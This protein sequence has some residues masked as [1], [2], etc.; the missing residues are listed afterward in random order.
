MFI[1]EFTDYSTLEILQ[2]LAWINPEA[3]QPVVIFYK[4]GVTW[5]A[6]RT[7]SASVSRVSSARSSP[8]SSWTWV[9]QGWIFYH[10]RFGKLHLWELLQAGLHL[11]KLSRGLVVAQVPQAVQLHH[12]L[13]ELAGEGLVLGVDVGGGGEVGE[14]GV[15]A[16]RD[17]QQ[18]C[19]LL[20]QSSL[21]RLGGF[22]DWSL[23]A[24]GG[25]FKLRDASVHRL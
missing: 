21:L 13:L 14:E 4:E 9:Q 5:R 17:R 24:N 7:S 16:Q 20:F 18:H 25:E 12:L 15:H 1:V 6:A 11:G 23:W 8:S 3:T 2:L 10:L 19:L 22:G